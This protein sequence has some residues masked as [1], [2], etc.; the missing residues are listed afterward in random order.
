MRNLT[1]VMAAMALVG[2]GLWSVAARAESPAKMQAQLYQTKAEIARA[3]GD[4]GAALDW[5]RA[6]LGLDRQNAGLYNGLGITE[7][8][9]GQTE[10]ARVAFERALKLEPQ[11]A[12]TLN[13]LGAAYCLER[14]YKPSV[15]YLKKSLALDEPVAATHVNLAEAWMGQHKMDRAMTEYA[16]ALELDPDVLDSASNEGMIA[17]ISTPEQRAMISFLIARAYARRGNIEQALVYLQ[18]AKDLHY[19]SLGNVYTEPEFAGLWKDARLT[20]IVKPRMD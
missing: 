10:E 17:Q 1:T 4:Y 19:P 13:N 14:R 5:Y 11:N 20:A 15:R 2:A 18:R 7:L 16:R 3:R 8:K 9:L 6:A 12:N